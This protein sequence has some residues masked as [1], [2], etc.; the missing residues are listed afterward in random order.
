MGGG[1]APAPARNAGDA[2]P[3]YVDAWRRSELGTWKVVLRW[4][5]TARGGRLTDDVRIAQRPP[6]RLALSAGSVDARRGGR[7]L[8]CAAGEDG[9]LRC[10]DAGAARPYD[11]E[12][13]AGE[14][15][16]R[17]QLTGPG[18]I[19]DVTSTRDGCYQLRLR[20]PF[21]APPYGRRASY[22]F[23]AETGAPTLIE[24]ERV[25]GRDRQQ[26]VSVSARVDDADLAPP[27]GLPG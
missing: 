19:Y 2:A 8:S 15:V 7:M 3:A 16:L 18:R 23:D 11:E 5:R 14:R 26:A 10:R 13:A 22:C 6:D 4:E 9:R 24:V 12:V 20:V 17:D 21:P 25:E 1:P 27:P